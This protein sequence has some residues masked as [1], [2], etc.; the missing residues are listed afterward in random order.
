[1]KKNE[2]EEDGLSRNR[3]GDDGDEVGDGE[4]GAVGG[5]E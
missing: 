5:I 2:E 3:G 1:M 4:D